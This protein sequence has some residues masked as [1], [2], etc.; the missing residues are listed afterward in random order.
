[1]NTGWDGIAQQIQ[2]EM[3]ETRARIARNRDLILG[4]PDLA[5]H[6]TRPPL[7]YTRPDQWNGFIPPELF[8]GARNDSPRRA[9]LVEL[10]TEAEAR[11]A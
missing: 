7:G 10:L 3:T 8:D 5:E 11:T 2:A 1:M 9:A 6:L 4:H